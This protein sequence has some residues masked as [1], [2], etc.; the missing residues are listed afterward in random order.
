MSVLVY[1]VQTVRLPV[2]VDFSWNKGLATAA[3]W[4][5]L[6]LLVWLQF[7]HCGG[8]CVSKWSPMSDSSDPVPATWR[9]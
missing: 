1:F 7:F 6:S 3:T 8:P 4:R 9:R 5:R 2:D